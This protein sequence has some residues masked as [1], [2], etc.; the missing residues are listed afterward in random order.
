MTT[1][2]ANKIA[3]LRILDAIFILKSVGDLK[4]SIDGDVIMSIIARLELARNKLN[5]QI[6]ADD[7][8]WKP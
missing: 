1:R 6:Y 5:N 4:A 7:M 8:E 3:S 2:E